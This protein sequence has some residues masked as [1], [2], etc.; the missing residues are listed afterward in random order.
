MIDDGKKRT[1]VAAP[2]RN[3][4]IVTPDTKKPPASVRV[5]LDTPPGVGWGVLRLPL[6]FPRNRLL[7]NIALTQTLEEADEHTTVMALRGLPGC[8]P[9]P[10]KGGVEECVTSVTGDLTG[11][12]TNHS[13]T[14]VTA[15]MTP[16]DA[17]GHP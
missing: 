14:T 10:N 3:S 9:L 5:A 11:G 2:H 1:S 4:E 17:I 6:R 12:F 15:A 16:R 7:R 13:R 8:G